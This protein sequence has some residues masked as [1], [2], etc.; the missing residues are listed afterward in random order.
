MGCCL[1]SLP[2]ISV[3]ASQFSCFLKWEEQQPS[4]QGQIVRIINKYKSGFPGSASGKEP[5][6][7]CRRCSRCGFDPW[8]RKIPWRRAWQPTPVL[9]PGESH[10]Q[11]SLA[12]YSPSGS[13]QSDMT[14]MTEHTHMQSL[15]PQDACDFWADF[16]CKRKCVPWNVRHQIRAGIQTLQCFCELRVWQRLWVLLDILLAVRFLK[17]KNIYIVYTLR[18]RSDHLLADCWIKLVFISFGLWRNLSWIDLER[19]ISLKFIKICSLKAMFPNL[20]TR[21]VKTTEILP[22]C[23]FGQILRVWKLILR[24]MEDVIEKKVQIPWGSEL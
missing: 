17:K 19:V 24:N 13:K 6:C 15:T 18:D 23:G 2:L 3:C 10:R 5:S 8:V 11:R 7:Q 21:L 22:L 20:T 12:G 4:P 16:L 14:E 1:S 9:L